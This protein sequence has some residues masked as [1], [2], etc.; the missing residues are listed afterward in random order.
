MSKHDHQI[1]DIDSYHAHVYYDAGT[2]PAAESLGNAI[3]K[4]FGGVVKIGRWHDKPIG[5]HPVGSY[6]VVFSTALFPEI[7]PWLALNRGEVTVLVHPNT[8]ADLPD[9]RDYAL[10]LGQTHELNLDGLN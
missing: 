6:Q 1:D 7:V 9:H 4:R 5:P 8:G 3:D 10:W 2:K